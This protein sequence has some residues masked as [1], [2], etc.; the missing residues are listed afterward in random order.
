M[1]DICS[2]RTKTNAD[3]SDHLQRLYKF[4]KILCECAGYTIWVRAKCKQSTSHLDGCVCHPLYWLCM[5]PTVMVSH[6]TYD[7]VF[8]CHP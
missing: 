7:D 3:I 5:S 4:A 6:A 1:A 8:V 2:K